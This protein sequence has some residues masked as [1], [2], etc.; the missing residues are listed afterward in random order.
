MVPIHDR[1]IEAET[2]PRFPARL[3]EFLQ[4]VALEGGDMISKSVCFESNRQKPSWCLLV[5]RCISSGVLCHPDPLVFLISILDI[6]SERSSDP[7]ALDVFSNA[8]NRIRL[9]SMVHEKLYQAKDLSHIDI[10][11]YIRSLVDYLRQSMSERPGN[12]T[13]SLSVR[14]VELGINRAMTCGLI[15]N[16]LVFNA[17]KHAY[18][19]GG[20]AKIRIEFY[21]TGKEYVLRIGDRGVGFPRG[22]DFRATTSLDCSSSVCL[23]SSSA[24]H[25]ADTEKGY[26]VS[27]RLSQNK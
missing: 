6:Q 11:D 23:W 9:I 26:G 25:Y 18:P 21:A 10:A 13:V 17:L 3:G 1:V 19:R 15:I 14:D 12:V 4:N 5:S 16:E 24:A 22:L 20:R 27:N 7:A 2:D 8:R